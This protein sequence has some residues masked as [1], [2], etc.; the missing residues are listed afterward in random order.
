MS[1]TMDLRTF[2][3][4]MTYGH[5]RGVTQIWLTP[6][7][8]RRLYAEIHGLIRYPRF[9]EAMIHWDNLLPTSQELPA[10]IEFEGIKIFHA[11]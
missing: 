2:L 1:G 6:G 9:D 7:M 3:M 11:D 5:D 4:A 10:F 8:F